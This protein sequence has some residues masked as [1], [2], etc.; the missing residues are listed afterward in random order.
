MRLGNCNEFSDC[1]EYPKKYLLKSSYQNKYSPKFSHAKKSRNKKFQTPKNLLI[2]PVTWNTE[3]TSPRPLEGGGGKYKIFNPNSGL[4]LNGI[5]GIGVSGVP[6]SDTISP[7]L[8]KLGWKWAWVIARNKEW[9]QKMARLP[10]LEEIV[11]KS[12][13][14]VRTVFFRTK[15]RTRNRDLRSFRSIVRLFQVRS[16]QSIVRSFHKKVK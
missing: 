9:L 5:S 13:F 16:F 14:F 15:D 8:T 4:A 2:I 12:P 10:S 1:F 6:T 7:G 3:Y 11:P